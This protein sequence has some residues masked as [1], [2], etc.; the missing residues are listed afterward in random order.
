[1]GVLKLQQLVDTHPC[2][3][4]GQMLGGRQIKRTQL[5]RVKVYKFTRRAGELP[6]PTPRL[7]SQIK[8]SQIKHRKQIFFLRPLQDGKNRC[9]P[10][11]FLPFPSLM[12]NTDVF[13]EISMCVIFFSVIVPFKQSISK[14]KSLK[15]HYGE[16]TFSLLSLSLLMVYII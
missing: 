15:N 3:S 1:M 16:E 13:Q 7:T 11:V 10:R 6:H 5:A 8:S 2:R 4:W 14:L 12:V 9:G